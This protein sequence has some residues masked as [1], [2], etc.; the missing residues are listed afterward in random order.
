MRSAETSAGGK[1]NQA[2]T[3]EGRGTLAPVPMKTKTLWACRAAEQLIAATEM[4]DTAACERANV[5]LSAFSKYKQAME[6]RALRAPVS[7]SQAT[8]DQPNGGEE[9]RKR[10]ARRFRRRGLRNPDR[11]AFKRRTINKF[12]KVSVPSGA[13]GEVVKIKDVLLIVDDEE[14][15]YGFTVPARLRR[16]GENPPDIEHC[17]AGA[18]YGTKLTLTAKAGEVAAGAG[19]TLDGFIEMEKWL[20]KNHRLLSHPNAFLGGWKDPDNGIYELNVS[21]VFESVADGYKFGVMNDQDSIYDSTTG[22]LIKTGGANE[23][24]KEEKLAKANTKAE[25]KASKAAS[26]F[27]K[28]RKGH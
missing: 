7:E 22:K 20:E 13:T 27:A 14:N 28:K 26:K 17:V 8:G 11:D 15:T 24:A 9:E 4:S 6:R 18:I 5:P 10:S 16:A 3:C 19:L 1:I 25:R 21:L 12:G 23:Q 2:T